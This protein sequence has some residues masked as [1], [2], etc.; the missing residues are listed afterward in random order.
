M[1]KW[2]QAFYKMP[3]GAQALI[4]VG[5]LIVVFGLVG[6]SMISSNSTIAVWLG[7]GICIGALYL[8]YLLSEK[9]QELF[10]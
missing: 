1:D 7:I 10:K 3:V 5:M 4:L 8:A 6:P 2:K 9:I